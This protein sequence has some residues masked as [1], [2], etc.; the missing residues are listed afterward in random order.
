MKYINNIIVILLITIYIIYISL[1][2]IPNF[3]NDLFNNILFKI[4]I[5]IL[6]VYLSTNNNNIGG[7]LTGILLAL[8]YLITVHIIKDDKELFYLEDF[9]QQEED[10][11]EDMIEQSDKSFLED[12][13]EGESKMEGQMVNNGGYYPGYNMIPSNILRQSMNISGYYS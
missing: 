7:S 6:I 10:I 11:D 8:S 1:N 3:I 5:L 12:E 4:L 13:T 9:A 2:Y